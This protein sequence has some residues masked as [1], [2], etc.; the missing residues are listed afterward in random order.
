[1]IKTCAT[2]K[3]RHRQDRVRKYIGDPLFCYRRQSAVTTHPVTGL[4]DYEIKICR[5]ERATVGFF[6]WLL[7]PETC[8]P[9]G[10]FWKAQEPLGPE[11]EQVWDDN[12]DKLYED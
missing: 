4:P 9:A 2:C 6:E 12:V 3:H 1:M 5:H 8:G 11:F 10:K 7:D